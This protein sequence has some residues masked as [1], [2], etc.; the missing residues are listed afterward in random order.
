VSAAPLTDS[1]HR[2]RCCCCCCYN[3]HC[4]PPALTLIATRSPAAHPVS[5]APLADSRPL[6]TCPML[7]QAMGSSSIQSNS[8]EGGRPNELVSTLQVYLRSSSGKTDRGWTAKQ[9]RELG[10][11]EV[12]VWC[13]YT[14]MIQQQ[15][16]ACC[17]RHL[18]E[19]QARPMPRT[20]HCCCSVACIADPKCEQ[21]I[22][23]STH[24][25]CTHISLSHNPA[26]P[27]EAMHGCSLACICNP[28][29]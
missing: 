4:Q 19:L 7:P 17:T 14:A 21:H 2:F 1:C 27:P 10:C 8:S 3:P 5:A 15:C 23:T 13:S 29:M 24:V 28:K 16:G 25:A 11:M 6:C 18:P 9:K 22:N 12:L 20:A 26:N